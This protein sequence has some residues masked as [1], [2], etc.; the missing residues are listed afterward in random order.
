MKNFKSISA[1]IVKLSVFFHIFL[2][3]KIV[4]C[5]CHFFLDKIREVDSN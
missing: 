5:N 4:S 2:F 3:L 1:L